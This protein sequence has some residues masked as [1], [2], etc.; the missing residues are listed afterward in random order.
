MTM[1]PQ[2]QPQ[3]LYPKTMLIGIILTCLTAMQTTV[4]QSATES[5]ASKPNV[6]VIFADDLGPGDVNT[7]HKE[8][9]GKASPIPTPT[10]DRLIQSGIRFDDAHAPNSLCA[11]SRFSML[12]GNY[13][14]RNY[15]PFGCWP[16][17][18]DSGVDPKFTTSARIAKAGGYATAF[19]GKWGCGGKIKTTGGQ[20]LSYKNKAKA[21]W[22]RIY[23]AANHHGFDYAYELPTGIQGTPLAYYENGQWDKLKPSSKLISV[24]PVQNGYSVSRKH[25][26]LECAGDSHWDPTLAG[27]RLAEKA[28]AYVKKHR[29]EKPK[30]P[31]F[32]YYCSQAVH[33]PHA[34]AKTLDG[35]KILG[36]TP[37]VHGD[38][39]RELDTQVG[40]I[41]KV[42]KETG[43]WKNT[44]FILTSDNGGLSPDA[45]AATAGHD[46]THGLRGRKGAIWEGGDRVPFIAVWPGKIKPGTVSHEPIVG[47][48]VVAT[49]AHLAGQPIDR[50]KVKDSLNLIPL[51]TGK[52]PAERHKILMQQS[53]NGPRYAI[54]KGNLK[55][56]MRAQSRKSLSNL[57]PVELFNLEENPLEDEARNLLKAPKYKGAAADLL[58]TY[59]EYRKTRQSTIGKATE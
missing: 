18:V 41:I 38:M 19:F 24:G 54:R 56:I 37:G 5:F 48:D 45:K 58:K 17:F 53:S 55:L 20:D 13:S 3:R 25:K 7:Y 34:P 29:S 31:F 2:S 4:A 23:N 32:L 10:M 16:P 15:N 47:H 22:T 42:L 21:D 46:P 6:V 9:T 40:M 28:V 33:I 11:P 14:W 50:K 27:P 26:D 30:Q 12:T 44:L 8:R 49:L 35:V 39:V 57:D 52:Q 1:S 36:S 59:L 43:A 51:L